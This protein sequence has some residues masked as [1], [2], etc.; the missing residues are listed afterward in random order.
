[1]AGQPKTELL[2]LSQREVW[3]NVMCH[4]VYAHMVSLTTRESTR[5]CGVIATIH[6]VIALVLFLYVI[7]NINVSPALSRDLYFAGVVSNIGMR[8]LN[9]WIILRIVTTTTYGCR[10][11]CAMLP[12]PLLKM[13]IFALKTEWI[14]LVGQWARNI[15]VG[16]HGHCWKVQGVNLLWTQVHY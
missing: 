14:R 12:Y 7:Y 8:T 13:I 10:R 9:Y 15:W 2:F 3:I 11:K 5:R 16:G 1:M 4:P 6:V